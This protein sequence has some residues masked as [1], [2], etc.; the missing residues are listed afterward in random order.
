MLVTFAHLCVNGLRPRPN[1][2]HFPDEL[3]KCIFFIKIHEFRLKC[4]R[5]VF[6]KVP[7]N[8]IPALV[9]IMAWRRPDDKPLSE[10]MMVRL[11]THICFTPPQW[12]KNLSIYSRIRLQLTIQWHPCIFLLKHHRIIRVKKPSIAVIY[13]PSQHQQ[14]QVIWVFPVKC[15]SKRMWSTHDRS[16]Y[17]IIG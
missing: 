2:R 12:V 7:V 4:H 15:L 1:G 13:P 17:C 8:N 10:P 14:S 9:Q 5:I 3:L 11:P 6:T 16:L